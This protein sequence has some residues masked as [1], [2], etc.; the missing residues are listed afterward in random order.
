MHTTRETISNYFRGAVLG[1]LVLFGSIALSGCV[2]SSSA[3]I[4]VPAT[5]TDEGSRTVPLTAQVCEYHL[6]TEVSVIQELNP[7][8]ENYEIDASLV[9]DF[10]DLYNMAPPVSD[11]RID[12]VWVFDRPPFPEVKL[13]FGSQGCVVD[14]WSF[15]REVYEILNP[16]VAKP[17]GLRV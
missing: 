3:E 9:Q 8:V 1:L 17:A 6:D 7:G 16:K 13:I 14:Q 2:S 12:Q 11:V 5:V 15:P 10:A 4:V